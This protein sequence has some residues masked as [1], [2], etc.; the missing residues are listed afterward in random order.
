MRLNRW[1]KNLFS[2]ISFLFFSLSIYGQGKSKINFTVKCTTENCVYRM[3]DGKYLELTGESSCREAFREQLNKSL[4]D[5]SESKNE[6]YLI[7]VDQIEFYE[8]TDITT[9]TNP[10]N[11]YQTSTFNYTTCYVDVT[12]SVKS[13]N[14]DKIIR[15]EKISWYKSEDVTNNRSFLQIL[16]GLNKDGS[17]YRVKSLSSSIFLKLSKQAA[18]K[19][20]KKA[21]KIIKKEND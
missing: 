14:E 1:P 5:Y 18:K 8:R 15:T 11:F 2:I 20:S 7:I 10:N 21:I 16:L 4:A 13:I 6:S 19:C 3:G 9:V 17:E 12:F